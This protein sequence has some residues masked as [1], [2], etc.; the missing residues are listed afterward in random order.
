MKAPELPELLR[1]AMESIIRIANS[2][3]FVIIGIVLRHD[4]PAVAIM[5][6]TKDDPAELLHAAG[7]LVEGKMQ[8]G[9]VV[10]SILLP[11]N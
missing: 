4:P 7:N 10:E 5:R 11:V 2:E 6:N 9:Q 1:D 3:K 8:A